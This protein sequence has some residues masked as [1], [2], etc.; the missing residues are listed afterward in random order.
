MKLVQIDANTLAEL[1]SLIYL[2][3]R[4]TL[5]LVAADSVLRAAPE[6]E[7][8]EKVANTTPNQSEASDDAEPLEDKE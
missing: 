1:R 3:G 8:P 6:H 7:Q 5:L 4:R 2:D